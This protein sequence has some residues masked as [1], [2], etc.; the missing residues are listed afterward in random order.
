MSS[1]KRTIALTLASLTFIPFCDPVHLGES[2]D[3]TADVTV[4]EVR[5]LIASMPSKS[6]SVDF[7]PTS[8]LKLCPS[9]FSEFIARLANLSF[10]EGTFPAKFK[11]AAVTP[12]LK[13]PSLDPDHP[14][15]YRPISNL[16]NISEIIERPF[17]S[18]LSPHVT[19]PPNFNLPIDLIIPLRLPFF[20]LLTI[21]SAL[22]TAVNQFFLFL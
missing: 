14:L 5:R 9:V 15:S 12:L 1:L 22:P 8:L 2:F 17:L 10:S 19:S 11:A 6:S 3:Y 13:N 18:I 7:I 21:F 16:N 4:D 20:T